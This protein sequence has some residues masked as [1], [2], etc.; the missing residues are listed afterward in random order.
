MICLL[1][2]E[3]E[4]IKKAIRSGELSPDKLVDMTS[5]ER[6]KFLAEYVGQEKAKEVNLL[7]EKKLLLKNQEKA[8]SDWARDTIGLSKEKKEATLEKIRATYADKKRRLE[9]PKENELFLNEIVS[10]IYSRKFKTEIS[11]EEA[12][13]ITELSQDL[14]RA[15]EKLGN[16]ADWKTEQFELTG[17]K[18]EAL[19]AG[20]KEVVLNNYTG[21]LKA[22][23]NKALFLSPFK[24]S[25]LKK[26]DILANNAKVSANFVLDNSRSLRAS[27]DNSFF[28]RQGIKVL[29]THPVL[30]TKSFVKSWGDIAKTIRY[31][32]KKGDEILDATKA[33]IYSRENYMKGRYERGRRLDIGTGEEEFPTSAP[34]KIPVL[35]RGFKASEVAY[36]SGAMRLR[37]DVADKVF[38]LAEKTGVDLSNKEEVGSINNLVNSMTGR[39][40]LGK[41]EGFGKVLNKAF[42][43][44]KFFK[45]NLDTL[46][47]FATEK[48]AFTRKQA[49]QNLLKIGASSFII[50]MTASALGADVEWDRRSANFGKI[51]IGNKRFD[52]TGGM[53]GLI[54]LMTRL[55]YGIAGKDA[56]KSSVTGLTSKIN[57]GYGTASG[58][59]MIWGFTENKFSPAFSVMKELINQRTF[60]GDKPTLL[61]QA[62]NLTIPIVIEGAYDAAEQEGIA[63]ALMVAIADGIGISTNVYSFTDN[64][65]NKKGKELLQFK[66][67]VGQEKFDKANEKYND[68]VNE[69]ILELQ[70]SKRWENM[71]NEEKKKDLLK[72]KNEIKD[73]IFRQHLFKYRSN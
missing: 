22:E 18:K 27:F 10:D 60:A 9:D 2:I 40:S 48:T 32:N 15:R 59:D 29:Y 8:M 6:R 31:G 25:E 55:A 33:E 28:G 20:A 3:I 7:F 70:K 39:G 37:A 49:A 62:K 66:E 64:W 30:W 38:S 13:T 67:K 69:K 57:E 72:K 41:A 23:A 5:A 52:V 56:I 4:K 50:L 51:K 54:I 45:S 53:G 12:Q 42:F 17:T 34:S 1:P 73:K 63:D 19:D 43:S 47:G 21:G 24:Q 35:G 46:T 26:G 11:L 14:K 16:L 65:N 58:M 61:N 44:A 71:D 68:L 36:E